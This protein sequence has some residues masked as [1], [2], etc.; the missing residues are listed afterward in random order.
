MIDY[1]DPMTP[2]Y[3]TETLGNID[4]SQGACT[5]S[6]ADVNQNG[7]VSVSGGSTITSYGIWNFTSNNGIVGESTGQTQFANFWSVGT[8]EKTGGTG[9]TSIDMPFYG[10]PIIIDTGVLAFDGSVS[11]FYGSI[12]GGGTFTLG[13]GG[14]DAINS[15]TSI[16]AQTAW[17]VTDAKTIVTLNESLSYSG[18]FV[19]QSGADLTLAGGVTLTLANLNGSGGSITFD[20]GSELKFGGQSQSLFAGTIDGFAPGDVIDLTSIANVAGSHAN[21]NDATNVLTITEGSNT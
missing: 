9:T 2:G 8:L 15:G 6:W 14:Q 19:D 1:G 3:G 21:M 12:S 20:S 10:S 5:T 17:T 16:A 7:V 18:E 11:D 4:M 13:D